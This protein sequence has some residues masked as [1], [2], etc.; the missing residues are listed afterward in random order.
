MSSF[1]LVK[2][3]A[4]SVFFSSWLFPTKPFPTKY[5]KGKNVAVNFDKYILVGF[6]I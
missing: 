4:N 1:L 2:K 3:L 5:K 6:K